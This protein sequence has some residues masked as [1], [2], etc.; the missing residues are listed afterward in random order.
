MPNADYAWAPALPATLQAAGLIDVE[1]SGSA[2]VLIGGTPAAELLRLTVEAVR[3][4]IPANV[5]VDGGLARL[6]DPTAFEPGV[7]W[8]SAWGRRDRG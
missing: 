5:D 8:Y 3:E 4:R 1:A 6:R 2:D 7:V